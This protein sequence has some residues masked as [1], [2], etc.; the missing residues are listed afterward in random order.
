MDLLP[1]LIANQITLWLTF[2]VLL[3]T[4]GLGFTPLPSLPKMPPLSSV[5][6]GGR[7]PAA[8]LLSL[9]WSTWVIVG[10][11]SWAK[12]GLQKAL[13]SLH[14]TFMAVWFSLMVNAVIFA[15]EARQLGGAAKKAMI[16]AHKVLNWAALVFSVLG[17]A[18]IAANKVLNKSAGLLFVGAFG[19]A[20]RSPSLHAAFALWWTALSV[21]MLLQGTVIQD[22]GSSDTKLVASIK[23]VHRAVGAMAIFIAFGAT[24]MGTWKMGMK[25]ETRALGAI[26]ALLWLPQVS[27]IKA[28][29]STS[30]NWATDLKK[31]APVVV[32]VLAIGLGLI[33]AY[34]GEGR[35]AALKKLL[36]QQGLVK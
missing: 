5:F 29:G 10:Q 8:R 27:G 32:G 25:N 12:P 15:I 20:A 11:S 3:S 17:S 35:T 21:W 24:G 28:L 9:G 16:D 22:G 14:P 7:Y 26:W 36:K 34:N 2:A 1:L 4:V 30:G 31:S 18:A 19:A 33:F 13:F 23:P 6:Y